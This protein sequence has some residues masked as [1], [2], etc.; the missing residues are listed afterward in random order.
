MKQNV[1]LLNHKK[2]VYYL[3]DLVY[4]KKVS[5]LMSDN[6]GSEVLDD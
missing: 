6:V 3:Y 2:T 1:K 5:L 4:N